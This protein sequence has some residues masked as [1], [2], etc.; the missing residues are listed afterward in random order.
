MA[1]AAE[2]SAFG[3]IHHKWICIA[4]QTCAVSGAQIADFVES[5]K[6]DLFHVSQPGMARFFFR[7]RMTDHITESAYEFLIPYGS[8]LQVEEYTA[9]FIRIQVAFRI[10][11]QCFET[12][13]SLIRVNLK[14][15]APHIKQYC[16]Y[17]LV[18]IIM[19]QR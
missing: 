5:V 18:Y 12:T 17:H 16:L 10:N 4:G 7:N 19:I 13:L 1:I 9:L 15:H 14:Q 8:T 6:R 11:A 3:K 2:F